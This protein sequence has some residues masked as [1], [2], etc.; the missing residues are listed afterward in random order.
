M[1]SM[2]GNKF[3]GG[4]LG[5]P[6][7]AGGAT[8]PPRIGGGGIKPIEYGGPV[9][10]PIG[11][12][13][14]QGGGGISPVGGLP[15]PPAA[16]GAMDALA[17]WNRNEAVYARDP[18]RRPA[19]MGY[20]PDGTINYSPAV[21]GSNYNGPTSSGPPRLP[22]VSTP[23]PRPPAG[24]APPSPG[25]APSAGALPPTGGPAAPSNGPPPRP[26]PNHVWVNGIGW[27]LPGE[28]PAAAPPPPPGYGNGGGGA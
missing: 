13:P 22:G 12:D 25:A 26:S 15:R 5:P 1:Q 24:V 3:G 19:P 17:R 6:V 2:T 4:Y 8:D 16:P 21:Y 9:K 28:K 23:P 7:P 20:R 27:I 14:P 10:P 11:T 18:S